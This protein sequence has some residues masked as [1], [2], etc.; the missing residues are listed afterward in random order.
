[1]TV[2]A[3]GSAQAQELAGTLKK[4]KE[5]NTITIGYRDASV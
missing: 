1:M 4:I 3:A 5:T 2:L